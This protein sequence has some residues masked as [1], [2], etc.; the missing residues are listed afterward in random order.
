MLRLKETSLKSGVRLKANS[1][2]AR[3]IDLGTIEPK[4]LKDKISK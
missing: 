2:I 3:I 1:N 4:G